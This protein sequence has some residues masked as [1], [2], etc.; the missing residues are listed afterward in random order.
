MRGGGATAGILG[1]GGVTAGI[2]GG[3]GAT[4]GIMGGGGATAGIL[5][6]GGATVGIMG[7]GNN[8]QLALVD[9]MILH[10]RHSKSNCW[11][12]FGEKVL[13]SH[14]RCW[15]ALVNNLTAQ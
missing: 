7:G 12:Y 5:G 1:G 6:G 13:P 15:T 14:H 11:M 4:A 2:M 9:H 3:G 8:G 10:Y